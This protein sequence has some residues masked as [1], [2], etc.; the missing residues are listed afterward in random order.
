MAEVAGIVQLGPYA[1][2]LGS[3]YPL[4]SLILLHLASTEARMSNMTHSHTRCLV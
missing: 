4:G 2:D 3:G 1:Y